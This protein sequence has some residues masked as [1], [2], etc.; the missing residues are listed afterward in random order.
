M[1]EY[2]EESYD[3]VPALQRSVNGGV[4]LFLS[5]PTE[6]TRHFSLRERPSIHRARANERNA[7][8]F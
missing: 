1:E 8:V 2:Q 7:R 6:C 5:P 4:D 3:S